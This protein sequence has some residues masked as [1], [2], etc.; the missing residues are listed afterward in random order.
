ME[1]ILNFSAPLDVALLDRVVLAMHRSPEPERSQADR[2]LTAFREHVEAWTRVDSVLE[3]PGSS[4]ETKY[5]ALQILEAMIKYRWK[6][7]PVE[8]RD[9]IKMYLVQKII[10]VRKF[11]YL[12]DAKFA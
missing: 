5:F 12:S 1:A 4:V 6:K 11:W 7:L 9:G 3:A 8:Q 10:T 2:V